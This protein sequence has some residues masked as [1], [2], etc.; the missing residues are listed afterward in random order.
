METAPTSNEYAIVNRIAKAQRLVEILTS[1]GVTTRDQLDGWGD[2]EWDLL[3]RIDAEQCH[4]KYRPLS[5]ATRHA[6]RALMPETEPTVM[7]DADVD[8]LFAGLS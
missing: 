1:T 8:A 6:T 4:R 5:S 2:A 7:S 3:A